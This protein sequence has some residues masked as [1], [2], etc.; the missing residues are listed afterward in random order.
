[1]GP[2]VQDLYIEKLNPQNPNQYEIDGQ[3]VDMDIIQETIQVAGGESVSLAVRSTRHGP[4]VSDTYG[5]LEAIS[6]PET[7]GVPAPFAIALRWTALEPGYVFRAILTFN[8]AQDWNEFR[9]GAR[10]FSVPAQ[11]LVYADVDGN[12]GYQSPGN[13]PIRAAGDGSLPVPGWT[14]EYEWNG[15]IPFEQL[16]FTFNPSEGYIVTANNAVVEP[17]YPYLITTEW[18]Y[19]YRAERI[20][21]LIQGAPGP[22]TSEY[23]QQMQGD[24]KNLNAVTLLPVLLALPLSDQ[25]LEQARAIFQDWDTQNSLDSAPAALFSAFWKNLLAATFHD[26]LPP[27]FWPTGGDRYFQ[28]MRELVSQPDSPWWDNLT[29]APVESRDA[30][31]T[32]AFAAAV[33]ELEDLQGRDPQEWAWGEIHRVTFRNASFGRSGITPIEALFNRGPFQTSG[34]NDIVNATSWDASESYEVR[35]LPS[36]RMIVDLGDLG[37]SLAVLTTGQSGHAYHRHYFDMVTLWQ[38]IRYHPMRWERG[39]VEEEAEGLLRLAP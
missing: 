39:T 13:I 1:M 11:N 28:M 26:E 22:V 25:R 32:Q 30:I 7:L 34:S 9:E 36:M 10:Y 29:T 4:V 23:I 12:I 15:Y 21:E 35:A 6:T 16:P 19:G 5:D 3:W 2:D 17:D 8:R 20:V 18:A 37:R 24:N 33:A 38:S 14:S 31:F 27:D